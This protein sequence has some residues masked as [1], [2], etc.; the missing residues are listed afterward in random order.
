MNGSVGIGRI[1]PVRMEAS[2]RLHHIVRAVGAR[3]LGQHVAA[4]TCECTIRHRSVG[5]VQG[6]E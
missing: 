4:A 6:A 3:G 2:Q 1:A 5:R